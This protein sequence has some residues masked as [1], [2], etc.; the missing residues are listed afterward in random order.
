MVQ[1]KLYDVIVKY[2]KRQD[3]NKQHDIKFMLKGQ[4]STGNRF[5]HVKIVVLSTPKFYL[6]TK[7]W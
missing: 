1:S 7:S 5:I 2:A 6:V 3:P 4:T